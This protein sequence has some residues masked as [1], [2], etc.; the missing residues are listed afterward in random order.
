MRELVNLLGHDAQQRQQ[1]EVIDQLAQDKFKELAETV[2]LQRAGN[3]SGAMALVQTGAG[4]QS[5]DRLRDVLGELRRQ[6]ENALTT[7]NN[8]WE[9]AATFSD[10]FTWL[11]SLVLLFLIGASARLAI[12]DHRIRENAM[13]VRSGLVGLSAHLQGEQSLE[14]LGNNALG[15]LASHLQ[16]RVAAAY[17]ALPDGRFRRFAGYALPPESDARDIR[18]GDGLLGQAARDKRLLHLRDAPADYLIVNSRDAAAGRGAA[19]A[20]GG[21]AR[22][23][24]G[25]RGTGPALKESQARLETQQAE[26]EQINAQLEEQTQLLESQKDALL[27]RA[28]DAD[29]ARPRARSAPAVQERVP[30]QHEPRAAHAAQLV[31]DPRQAARRQ[32]DGNLTPSR[33]SSRRRSRRPAT[34]CWR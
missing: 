19:D 31:A 26:L 30:R 1:L 27:D 12:R 22:Q 15:H 3:T 20:A 9:A 5:M 33:S 6:Q 10:R 4:K 13:W 34:I 14:T 8:A 21:A 28:D 23:Q 25:A 7:Q 18:P 24:R 2:R 11:S 32:Q 29:R 16:A 17:I